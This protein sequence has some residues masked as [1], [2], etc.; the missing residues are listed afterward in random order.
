MTATNVAPLETVRDGDHLDVEAIATGVRDR[1][2]H[3]SLHIVCAALDAL[4]A[5]DAHMAARFVRRI[6]PAGGSAR[7]EERAVSSPTSTARSARRPA[8]PRPTTTGSRSTR[9]RSSVGACAP[10]VPPPTV[11]STA[12]RLV[13]KESHV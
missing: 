9:P 8:R 12:I 6:D 13:R 1:V 4:D 5:L 11:P 3:V 10:T 2:D 7:F